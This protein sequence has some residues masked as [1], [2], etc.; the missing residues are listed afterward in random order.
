MFNWPIFHGL[1]GLVLHASPWSFRIAGAEI[2]V[3][4]MTFLVPNQHAYSVVKV[5]LKCVSCTMEVILTVT[6]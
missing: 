6:P 1:C 4:H 5:G 2:F 3:D